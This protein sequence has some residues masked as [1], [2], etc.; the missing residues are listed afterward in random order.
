MVP[1]LLPLLLC[2]WY[3]VT[4][5]KRGSLSGECGMSNSKS[6]CGSMKPENLNQTVLP[7]DFL[8][9]CCVCVFV[10]ACVCVEGEGSSATENANKSFVDTCVEANALRALR[11]LSYKA[12]V[13]SAQLLMHSEFDLLGK[14]QQ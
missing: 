7:C 5:A 12:S 14:F 2:I 8:N 4:A 3:S 13:H 9:L 1:F 6:H 10:L 11:C